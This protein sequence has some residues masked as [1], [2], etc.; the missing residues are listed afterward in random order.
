MWHHIIGDSMVPVEFLRPTTNLGHLAQICTFAAEQL[1][2]LAVAIGKW[3]D[4]S[5]FH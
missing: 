5:V 1:L 3:V 2:S 4:V